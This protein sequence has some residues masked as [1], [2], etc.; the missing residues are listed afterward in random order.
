VER[1][2]YLQL[3]S[4][5]H[6]LHLGRRL[7]KKG[8]SKAI[9][10]NAI[11]ST[12][13]SAPAIGEAPIPAVAEPV[14]IGL[15]LSAGGL[16]GAAHVGV[17]RQLVHHGIRFDMIVGVSAGAVIAA[18]YA[19]VG[20]DLEEL[21]GDAAAFRGRH[22]LT[23]SLSVHLGHRFEHRLERW[24]GVIPARLR[25]L[26]SASFDRLHHGVQC[27]GIVCH[28]LRLRRPHY[29]YT[30][31]EHGISLSDAVRASASIPRLFPAISVRCGQETLRL[32]DG[33]ISDA[34]PLAFARSSAIGA[35]HLIVSDCR[36]VGRIPS[37]DAT[38]AW[39]RPRMPKTG[40][41]WSPQGGLVS[42]VQDGEEAITEPTL[43]RILAWLQP[44]ERATPLAPTSRA[45]ASPACKLD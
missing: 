5:Y 13:R 33:G 27:L 30:G 9:M 23:H 21:I 38:T 32:T 1:R 16:R 2:R 7:A 25:Q 26:E 11:A 37:I 17:I 34:V 14:R 18:Y 20:L 44:S 6:P 39:I 10:A 40:T 36:W 24:R 15:V 31:S 43:T 3:T 41:L 29:S 42:A 12:S 19:A 4:Q 22:L 35:T 45:A 8:T 28:D